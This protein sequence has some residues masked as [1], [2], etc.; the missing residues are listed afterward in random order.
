MKNREYRFE[1][2]I[3]KLHSQMK[4]RQLLLLFLFILNLDTLK[5]VIIIYLSCI[6]M[7]A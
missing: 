6:K 2:K 7:I 4:G 5:K 3:K 1:K